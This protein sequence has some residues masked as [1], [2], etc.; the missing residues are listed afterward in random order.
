MFGRKKEEED[1]LSDISVNLPADGTYPPRIIIPANTIWMNQNNQI[2]L[3]KGLSV[4]YLGGNYIISATSNI[5]AYING[6]TLIGNYTLRDG[7]YISSAKFRGIFQVDPTR[8]YRLAWEEAE[9]VDKKYT[10]NLSKQL[11]RNVSIN[12]QGISLDG[13]QN[14]VHWRDISH[15]FFYWE[16]TTN[17]WSVQISTEKGYAP[18]NFR[19]CVLPTKEM[20]TLLNYLIYSAPYHLSIEHFSRSTFPD[21][22]EHL[23][24]QKIII[25]AQAG[26]RELPA[27]VSEILGIATARDAIIDMLKSLGMLVG[28]STAL[29]ILFH[30]SNGANFFIGFGIVFL[31]LLILFSPLFWRDIQHLR[32]LPKFNAMY[33]TSSATQN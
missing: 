18:S 16:N 13:G 5:A 23:A 28:F 14:I 24:F 1:R 15:L 10:L 22:F 17:Y 12:N 25:P 29:S 21:A 2:T 26:K 33:P 20:V 19:A 3:S 4:Q 11:T 8:D 7:D 30:I 6:K 27:S 9:D 32:G 31:S